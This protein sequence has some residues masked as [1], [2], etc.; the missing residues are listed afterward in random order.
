MWC[1]VLFTTLWFYLTHL[2]LHH[3]SCVTCFCHH[4]LSTSGHDS[5]VWHY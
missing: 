5:L 2:E 3:T 4:S 1:D